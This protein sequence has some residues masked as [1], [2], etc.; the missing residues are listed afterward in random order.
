MK[1]NYQLET[2]KIIKNIPE[3]YVPTL[4][5]H[6]CCAPCSSYV[7]EYLSDFFNITVLYYNPNI[8]SEEEYKKRAKEQQRLIDE[9]K[10]KNKV[11]LI[12]EEYKPEEFY[13][14]AKGLEKEPEGGLRCKECFKLRL[15]KTAQLA[16]E[17]GFDYFTTTLTISPL[18]NSQ[19]LNEIGKEMAEKYEVN[20]LFSDFKKKS[21]Y[22]RSCELSEEYGLYRQNFCGCVFSKN[23]L[24]NNADI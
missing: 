14:K 10:L 1:I 15:E 9:M 21:G 13:S 8:D 23:K 5:L 22:L 12:V 3:N 11:E 18:K 7:I 20:Y 2:D 24:D 19:I 16:K 6:S 4:L 17:K